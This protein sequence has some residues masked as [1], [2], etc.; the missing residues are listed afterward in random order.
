MLRLSF[1][2]ALGLDGVLILWMISH[3]FSWFS[4]IHGYRRNPL[5]SF[6]LSVVQKVEIVRKGESCVIA[7]GKALVLGH[8]FW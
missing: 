1:I 4:C 3:V 6:F 2:V 8:F 5:F 7:L